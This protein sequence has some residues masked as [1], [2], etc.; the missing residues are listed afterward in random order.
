MEL[1]LFRTDTDQ[2]LA[3]V[4]SDKARARLD[5]HTRARD[6]PRIG[7]RRRVLSHPKGK[8]AAVG[9][10]IYLSLSREISLIRVTRPGVCE[11]RSS[12][13]HH[14]CESD[15]LDLWHDILRFVCLPV[16]M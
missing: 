4:V 12:D 8:L 9:L 6:G 10:R 1:V 2:R 11:M 14:S 5:V 13:D 7:R 15:R 3:L 16:I